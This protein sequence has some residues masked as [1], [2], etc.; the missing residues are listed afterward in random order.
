MKQSRERTSFKI[1]T[2][3]G[4]R[5]NIIKIDPKLKQTIIHT[6]QHYAFNMSES[7]F[8]DMKLPKPKFNLECKG[9]NIGKM[10]DKLRKLFNKERPNMVLVF[11][12]TN[13]SLAGGLAAAY[14]NIPVAHVEAGLRSYDKSMPEETN[15]VVLDHIATVRF[16]PTTFAA[17]NLLKEGIK[18]DVFVV[19]DP[20]FDAITQF[21]PLKKTKDAGKYILLTLHRNFNADRKVNLESIFNAIRESN[22]KVI[23]P[24]HPRTKESIKRFN[25]KIPKNIRII[26]PQPYAKF[27]SLIANAKKVITD[28]GGVQREA[29]WFNV[30]VII[31][32]DVTE[33]T[34]IITQGGGV[35]V[36]TS[37]DKILEAIMTFKS[38]LNA[39]PQYGANE[40][41]RNILYRYV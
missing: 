10:I 11:G 2:V 26:E 38:R 28:S 16:C 8:K 9:K 18:D 40:R 6:G 14:E 31:L 30:P 24:I 33:W 19:G 27:L 13:S 15:R 1:F 39:P 23:F 41:I 36:G 34:N 3:I 21:L 4:A 32:R 12:D 29:F 22:E 7:F 25:I 20:S 35:L 17:L 5:P 37:R